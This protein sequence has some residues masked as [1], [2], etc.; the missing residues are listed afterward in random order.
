MVWADLGALFLIYRRLIL[1]ST[2]P[3]P[4]LFEEV[5][6]RGNFPFPRRSRQKRGK[7]RKSVRDE[8]GETEEGNQ[9]G[10][11]P[12]TRKKKSVV[13]EGGGFHHRIVL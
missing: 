2:V 6:R 12:R 9:C 11:V 10:K 7:E 1:H 13:R 4:V 3:P 8:R 5:F